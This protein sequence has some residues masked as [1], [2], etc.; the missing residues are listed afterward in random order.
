MK[1]YR[2]LTVRDHLLALDH[3]ESW[4][5]ELA[6]MIMEYTGCDTAI[7]AA[8]ALDLCENMRFGRAAAAMTQG[9]LRICREMDGG[10]GL[11]ENQ[12][13]TMRQ[14]LRGMTERLAPFFRE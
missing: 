14:L 9:F 8:R 7:A 10:R 3:D 11:S 6:E 13:E 4:M 12:R 2:E 5:A 1:T